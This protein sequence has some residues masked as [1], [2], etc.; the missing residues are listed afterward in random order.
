[1][2]KEIQR[3]QELQELQWKVQEIFIN[4]F[5]SQFD[6]QKTIK[7]IKNL[8]NEIEEEEIDRKFWLRYGTMRDRED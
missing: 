7:V 3:H 4:S 2:E 1:M 5:N 8:F 6:V